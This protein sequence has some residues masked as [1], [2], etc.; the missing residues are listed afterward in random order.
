MGY[1]TCTWVFERAGKAK[2]A[3]RLKCFTE[4]GTR[5]IA[6]DEIKKKVENNGITCPFCM[7]FIKIN[8]RKGQKV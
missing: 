7:N 8:S 6:K 4:C 3:Q 1:K 5:L 2:C